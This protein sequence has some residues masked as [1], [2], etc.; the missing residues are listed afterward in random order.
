MNENSLASVSLTISDN[1]GTSSINTNF[2]PNIN[3]YKVINVSIQVNYSNLIM[4]ANRSIDR[5]LSSINSVFQK[6]KLFVIQTTLPHLTM[7]LI[8]PN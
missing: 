1:I 7:N 8:T 6:K 5:Y 4:S 3:P 2:T